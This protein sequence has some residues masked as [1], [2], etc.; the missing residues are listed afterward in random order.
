MGHFKI[1]NSWYWY[2]M[3]L[4][5]PTRDPKAS[6]F[7]LQWNIGFRVTMCSKVAIRV[8][9]VQSKLMGPSYSK[10]LVLA[11]GEVILMKLS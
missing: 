10:H 3:G 8:N 6:V 7:A 2:H 11:I 9:I 1:P 5:G 4:F